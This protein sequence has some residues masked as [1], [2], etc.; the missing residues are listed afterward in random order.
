MSRKRSKENQKQWGEGPGP[1]IR[2][3]GVT[4]AGESDIHVGMS[5]NA[6]EQVE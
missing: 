3:I 5:A 1:T 6:Q 4:G 2:G